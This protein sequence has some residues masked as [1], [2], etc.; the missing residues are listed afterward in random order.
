MLARRRFQALPR[1]STLRGA[2]GAAGAGGRARRSGPRA[3]HV[4]HQQGQH[5][6]T[7]LRLL[8]LVKPTVNKLRWWPW[9]PPAPNT[10]LPG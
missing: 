9:N 3:G 10:L 5:R 7:A 4:N 8:M 2:C 1:G 6:L